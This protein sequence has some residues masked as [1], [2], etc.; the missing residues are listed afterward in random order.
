MD[1]SL[2]PLPRLRVTRASASYPDDQTTSPL[3]GPSRL[4]PLNGDHEDDTQSTPRIPTMQHLD[5]N[6]SP[7]TT[8]SIPPDTPAARLRAL[9]ARVPSDSPLATPKSRAPAPSPPSEADSDF[10]PPHLNVKSTPHESLKELFSRALRDP[11]GTP[12][13]TRRNS[14]DLSEVD[15]SP[16]LDQV[17]KE[18]AKSKG[19]RKSMS[20]EELE[21]SSSEFAL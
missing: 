16:R 5:A 4:S 11:G 3:A 18:R 15:A 1:G 2:L 9:L 20:D 7:P 19:K 8:P 10:Y 17:Q 21:K 6:N 13:K 12:K 14:I